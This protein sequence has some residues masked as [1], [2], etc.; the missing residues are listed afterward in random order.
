MN[1][2]SPGH[3]MTRRN[4]EPNINTYL[5]GPGSA[6]KGEQL[7]YIDKEI[8]RTE[9]G[10]VKLVLQRAFLK[11]RRNSF[12][13]AVNLPTEL[14]ALIFE[15]TCL[16]IYSEFDDVCDGDINYRIGGENLGLSVGM[17]AVTPI[18]LGSIC[19]KWRHVSQGASRLWSTLILRINNRHAEEQ[20]SLLR[21]WLIRSALRPLSIRIVEDDNSEQEEDDDDWGIDVTPRSIIEVLAAHSHQWHTIDFFL[22]SSW[23][24]TLSRIKH[25]LPMLTKATLRI[26]EGSPSIARVSAFSLAPQLR[27][28]RLVGYSIA[29]VVLPRSQLQCL[30]EE[31]FGLQDCLDAL[32]LCTDLR[33]C[34]FEQVYGA[35]QPF[36]ALPVR[37]DILESLELLLEDSRNLDALL[38]AMTLPSL[39]ELVLS[40]SDEG[41][42]LQPIIPLIQRSGCKLQ[43][44]HLVG[45][46]PSEDKLI[47]LL[48]EVPM[49]KVLMLINPTT[50]SGGKVTQTLLNLLN[51]SKL[52]TGTPPREFDGQGDNQPGLS[53]QE[54]CLVPLL[55]KLEYQGA[56]GF[57]SHDFVEF[58]VSRWRLGISDLED[59][60]T[61]SELP[62]PSAQ[63]DDSA[64]MPS[65]SA[66]TSSASDVLSESP[67]GKR[68]SPRIRSEM[69]MPLRRVQL[70]SVIVTTTK[71]I[72]FDRGDAKVVLSLMQEGMHLDFLDDPNAD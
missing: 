67:Q 59:V 68:L 25:K 20:A 63:I 69:L 32:H 21:S 44:V 28:V 23:N 9:D 55:E 22:P 27:E 8:M 58:L 24:H 15:Y 26:A 1:S 40:L 7:A 10:I 37:H 56:T 41:S 34:Q 14:L 30:H 72:K 4:T 39:K 19:S 62:G 6:T 29:N 42:L 33:T 53:R 51:P 48:R 47:S 36:F 54:M 5:F 52:A 12:S 38:E 46:M 2:R 18:F 35:A 45:D 66:D 13:P 65:F 49:L 3:G 57:T 11:R 17:G 71:K 50:E 70:R 16:P 43:R 64:S 61:T 31:Y 60:Q